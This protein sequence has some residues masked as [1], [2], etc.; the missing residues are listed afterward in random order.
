[1]C[2]SHEIVG[3]GHQVGVHLHPL[4]ATVASAAQTATVFIQPKVSSTRLRIH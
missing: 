2:D 1:M 4:A 3:C